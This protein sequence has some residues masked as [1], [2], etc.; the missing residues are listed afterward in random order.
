MPSSSPSPMKRPSLTERAPSTHSLSSSGKQ[1]TMHKVHRPHV[2]SRHSRNVSH[3]KGLGKLGKVHSTANIASDAHPHPHQRKKSTG[4]T[5]P[6]SP[7]VPLV[8]RNASQAALAK[9]LSHGNLRKNHS[10]NTLARNLSHPALKKVGLAP[11]P[12]RKNKD[13][14]D[15]VFQIGDHSSEDEEEA[16]WEDSTT[17]SPEATRNNSK[18]STPARTATPNGESI[19]KEHHETS[20]S[21]P[22]HTSSPP[23]PSLKNNNR[24][25]PN[26]W[27]QS[28]MSPSRTP[29][30]P[31][32]LQQKTRGSRAPPA[33]STISAHVTPTQLTRTESSKSFSQI[34]HAEAA[35]MNSTPTTPGPGQ[36][37]LIDGGVSHFLEDPASSQRIIDEDLDSGS[38]SGFLSNYKPQPSESPE[39]ARTFHKPRGQQAPSRTQQKLELQRREMIR[40][41]ASTPTTPPPSGMGLDLGSSTSLQSRTGSRS[42]NRN[43]AGGRTIAGEIKAVKQDYEGAIKQLTVV[44]RFRSPIVESMIRLKESGTLPQDVGAVSVGGAFSKSRPQSRRGQ[45]SNNANGHAAKSGVSRSLEDRKPSPLALRSSS[46]GGGRVHFQRQTSHDD[47]EVTPS[48]GSLDELQDDEQDGLSPEE[49]LLRR[50]WDSREVYDSG[51]QVGPR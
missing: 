5:P 34:T 30:E 16:E 50:I 36:S 22:L 45:S 14:R 6:Q 44:R 29:P 48:H 13:R 42:R 23:Q 11:A 1:T 21:H 38:P 8:R 31:H 32:L 43:L 19:P 17:Q 46:R 20:I 40:A 15:N 28:D 33:M 35:S 41:S 4:S 2:V 37:S 3:G 7:G 49:A 25:A 27:K 26:L 39:K 18:T 12:K 24:S 9:N 10:A 51:E 47:I